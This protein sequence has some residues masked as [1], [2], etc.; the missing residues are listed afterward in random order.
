MAV[1][2]LTDGTTCN[3]P[4]GYA[5]GDTISGKRRDENGNPASVS[6]VVAEVLE[7]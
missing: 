7:A 5:E 2:L 6:G 3:A 1:Y 4:H